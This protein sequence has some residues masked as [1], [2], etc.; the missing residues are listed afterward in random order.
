MAISEFPVGTL[1]RSQP[2]GFR[3][4]AD[5]EQQ[6]SL[7]V[8]AL[9]WHLTMHVLKLTGRLAAIVIGLVLRGLF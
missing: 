2:P 7:M 9:L 5:S 8:E 6:E 1:A 4:K 3:V